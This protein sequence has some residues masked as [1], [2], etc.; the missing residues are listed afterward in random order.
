VGVGQKPELFEEDDRTASR[1]ENEFDVELRC[2]DKSLREVDG[3]G[4]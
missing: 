4:A 2:L 3:H 1:R